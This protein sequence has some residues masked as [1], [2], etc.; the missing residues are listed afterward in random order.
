MFL[1]ILALATAI[2]H[3][4]GQFSSIVLNSRQSFEIAQIRPKAL[5]QEFESTSSEPLGFKKTLSP[6]EK[7]VLRPNS[8]P[9]RL[10]KHPSRWRNAHFQPKSFPGKAREHLF[11]AAGVRKIL[12]PLKKHAL[13]PKSIPRQVP[14]RSSR[15]INTH[16]QPNSAPREPQR[17][18][19]AQEMR[20]F[21]P[22]AFPESFKNTLPAQETRNSVPRELQKHPPAR[23]TRMFSPKAFPNRFKNTI[24]AQEIRNFGPTAL[25]ETFKNTLLA[26]EIHTLGPTAFQERQEDNLHARE[27]CTFDLQHGY[28]APR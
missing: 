28:T 18:P 17:H 11:G 12:S 25:P 21:G 16:F 14:K 3:A 5:Q 13:Q 22:T 19:P 15:S 7:Y 6:L 1:P 26:Q 8:V 4:A 2:R 24:R 27:I 20:T 23:E 10:Q 9:R